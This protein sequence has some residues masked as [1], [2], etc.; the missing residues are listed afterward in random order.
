MTIRPSE[1]GFVAVSIAPPKKVRQPKQLNPFYHVAKENGRYF[2]RVF[3]KNVKLEWM[4]RR[5]TRLNLTARQR[6]QLDLLLRGQTEPR[7]RERLRVCLWAAS[8]QHTLDDLAALAHRRRSTI[9]NW[10]AKFHAGGLAGLVRRERPPGLISPVSKPEVQSGLE[11]GLNAGTWKSAAEIAS[12]LKRTHRIELSRKSVYYW[13]EKN[14]W[15]APGARRRSA[16]RRP[17]GSQGTN[18]AG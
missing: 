12:W 17:D 1:K 5:R 14:G 11:Q 10:L 16:E 3:Q 18:S 6:A 13:L 7:E 9:Q 4:G 15:Q 2:L 8:G